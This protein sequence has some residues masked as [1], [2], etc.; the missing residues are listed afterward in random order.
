MSNAELFQY[1]FKAELDTD[2]TAALPETLFQDVDAATSPSP[3]FSS[4][5]SSLSSP[6][7]SS[8]S[9]SS[10]E[11]SPV[12]TSLSYSSSSSPL[13]PYL[14]LDM[15]SHE[16]QEQEHS[17]QQQAQP[18]TFL[19]LQP[20]APTLLPSSSFSYRQLTPNMPPSMPVS[21]TPLPASGS[22]DNQFLNLVQTATASSAPKMTSDQVAFWMQRIQQLQQ[23]EQ[24]QHQL[25]PSLFSQPSSNSSESTS[26]ASGKNVIYPSPPMKDDMS[27]DSDDE[28]GPSHDGD[29]A[30]DPLKP[31]P[32]ELKKMTSKERRQLRNK[33]SARNFRV[34]RKGKS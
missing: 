32:S 6:P 22:T 4:S 12:N 24:H 25:A 10:Y 27:L 34:R 7:A 19:P 31:S 21:S 33:L 15:E 5:S 26:S 28:E 11:N 13:S 29:S 16:Q 2:L 20:A 8:S 1:L 3:S 30:S 17:Q 23:I 14:Q 9:A 18:F